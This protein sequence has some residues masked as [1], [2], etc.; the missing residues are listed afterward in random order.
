MVTLSLFVGNVM[1]KKVLIEPTEAAANKLLIIDNINLN[2]SVS[3]IGVVTT[4]VV[5]IEIP[6]VVNPDVSNDADWTPLVYEENTYVL[7][8]NNNRQSIPFRGVYRI[9]KPES[10]GNAFGIGFD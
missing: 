2:G 1:I 8:A 5:S 10:T 3:I 4:E 6:T 7:D 9:A